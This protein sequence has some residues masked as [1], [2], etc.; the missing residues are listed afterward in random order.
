MKKLIG[1]VLLVCG[2]FVYPYLSFAETY[3]ADIIITPSAYSG[4]FAG[5]LGGD[6]NPGP[7]SIDWGIGNAAPFSG[8][9]DDMVFSTCV[10]DFMTGTNWKERMRITKDGNVGIGTTSPSEK[11]EI[12]TSSGA[13]AIQFSRSGSGYGIVGIE[14]IGNT[15]FIQS[16]NKPIRF[17]ADN[18]TNEHMRIATSGNVGIGTTTPSEKLEVNGNVR[19]DAFLTGDIV[20]H[21]DDKPVWRMY[22]DEMGLYVQS[23]TTDKEYALV[24]EEMGNTGGV[25]KMTNNGVSD[26][27]QQLQEDNKALKEANKAI[28]SRLAKI[29]SLLNAQQ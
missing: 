15:M 5:F 24:F 17:S 21:K 2:S 3:H 23:L 1:L 11:L 7:N 10:G 12:D 9:T 4:F 19:A 22:E 13:S 26:K 16:N 6:G 29:E 8:L 28:E 18:F 14:G 27:I 25:A 20:F